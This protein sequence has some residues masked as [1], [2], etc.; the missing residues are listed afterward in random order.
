MINSVENKI[1]AKMKQNR[2]GKIFFTDY[3][4]KLGTPESCRKALEHLVKKGEIMRVSRG[5]YTIPQTSQYIGK[6]SPSVDTIIKAVMK[7]D[8]A[9]IV[10]TG[11]FAKNMLGLSTQL[12]LK[13]VYLTEGRSRKLK[14]GNTTVILKNTSTKNTAIKGKLSALAV[15]ALK[16][17]GKNNVTDEQIEKIV[18]ILKNENQKHLEHD[19]KFSPMW[20]KQILRKALLTE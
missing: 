6:V 13:I 8:N 4:D 9:N 14:I 5:I 10:P 7:K 16:S 17:I 19:I 18:N 1:L 11:S 20:I 12:P 3:F 2:R 15:Q